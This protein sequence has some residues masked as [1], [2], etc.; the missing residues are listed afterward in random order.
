MKKLLD[1][2]VSADESV[3]L[4]DVTKQPDA[5]ISE[6]DCLDFD[7]FGPFK[8]VGGIAKG[9]PTEDEIEAASSFYMKL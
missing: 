8:L 5:D 6:F 3:T 2:I 4:I 9:R 7:A 1:A